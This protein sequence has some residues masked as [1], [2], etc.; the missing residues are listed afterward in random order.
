MRAH[1]RGARLVPHLLAA[2]PV[3]GVSLTL[4]ISGPGPDPAGLLVRRAGDA[5]L[6]LLVLSLVPG[7]LRRV[8]GSAALMPARRWLGLYAF[9]YALLHL[10][11]WVTL[12]NGSDF[13]LVATGLAQ[14][15]FVWVGLATLLLMLPLA[16]TSTRGWQ[17]RL[18][19]RWVTLHRLAYAAAA[20]NVWH[21]AWGFTEQRWLP[22][23][24]PPLGSCCSASACGLQP[25]RGTA[26][27]PHARR[28]AVSRGARWAGFAPVFDSCASL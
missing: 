28:R 20:L 23:S 18:G 17:R 9:G 15:R 11:L 27:F 21:Y 8:T 4:M 1:F 26:N 24:S 16:I 22:W 19:R 14:N 5:G 2:L 13:A 25:G 6:A 7:A 12:Y 10:A 3:L